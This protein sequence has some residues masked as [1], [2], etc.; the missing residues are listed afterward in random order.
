VRLRV[1]NH[2]NDDELIVETSIHGGNNWRSCK[3]ITPSAL[4]LPAS[5][6][7]CDTCVSA[8]NVSIT[9]ERVV[10]HLELSTTCHPSHIES[11][12]S[13]GDYYLGPFILT[14]HCARLSSCQKCVSDSRSATCGWCSASKRCE[15][16]FD[17]KNG[18]PLCGKDKCLGPKGKQGGAPLEEC[19]SP[20][21]E[22]EE[23]KEE[24]ELEE[25]FLALSVAGGVLVLGLLYWGYKHQQSRRMIAMYES[26]EQGGYE[27]EECAELRDL[28]GED[29]IMNPDAGDPLSALM[30]KESVEYEL[31]SCRHWPVLWAGQ[32]RLWPRV[33][34]IVGLWA[35]SLGLFVVIAI[36]AKVGGSMANLRE[37]SCVLALLSTLFLMAAVWYRA[38]TLYVL[39]QTHALSYHALGPCRPNVEA[40]PISRMDHLHT[41]MDQHGFGTLIFSNS[42]PAWEFRG[43]HSV[44]AVP[45]AQAILASKGVGA[46]SSPAR[47]SIILFGAED[48]VSAEEDIAALDADFNRTT[49]HGDSHAGSFGNLNDD[50]LRSFGHS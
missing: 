41:T 25:L 27:E 8:T 7:W 4:G 24:G 6:N 20:A 38:G 10:G 43:F 40:F 46:S 12:E 14:E 36:N 44:E 50:D 45:R 13:R 33:R 26:L 21:D 1:L 23:H 35:M 11:Q 3:N 9:N 15:L 32:P 30:D 29:F 37:V 34:K 31:R 19:N 18:E 22:A 47:A 49:S 39:T 2:R 28:S 48:N 17:A 16:R 42:V 5:A